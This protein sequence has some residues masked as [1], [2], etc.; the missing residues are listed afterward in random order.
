MANHPK[1]RPAFTWHPTH[2]PSQERSFLAKVEA[3]ESRRNW[4]GGWV[5]LRPWRSA[6]CYPCRNP[7]RLCCYYGEWEA[8]CPSRSGSFDGSPQRGKLTQLFIFSTFL[9]KC[10]MAKLHKPSHFTLYSWYC[11]GKPPVDD[12]PPSFAAPILLICHFLTSVATKVSEDKFGT[13]VG[14]S[15]PM[16]VQEMSSLSQMPFVLLSTL[17]R[18]ISCC[19]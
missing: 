2:T 13:V 8:C 1:Q 5:N 15:T 19:F 12:A 10:C 4:G 6:P 9:A 18:L 17:Q 3:Q 16:H 14:K 7:S 11:F